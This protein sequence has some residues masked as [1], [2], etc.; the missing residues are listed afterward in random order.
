MLETIAKLG[1]S[2]GVGFLLG[3]VAV[4]WVEPTTGGGIVL[5]IVICVVASTVIGGIVSRLFGQKGT[6]LAKNYR[7][8]QSAWRMNDAEV[9]PMPPPSRPTREEAMASS[10]PSRTK[11]FISYSHADKK[12]LERLKRHLKPLVREGYLDCWDDTHIHPGDDWQQEIRT[13]LERH[14]PRC[15]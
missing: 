2:G 7:G 15:F 5:L 6:V 3:L 9:G 4:W 10:P 8:R 1:V 13:A 12:W 11:V 14:K